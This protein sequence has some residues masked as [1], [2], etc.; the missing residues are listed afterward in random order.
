MISVILSYGVNIDTI[1]FS[2]SFYHLTNLDCI[3][4][5]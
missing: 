3:Q 4:N 2:L 1:L 5:D